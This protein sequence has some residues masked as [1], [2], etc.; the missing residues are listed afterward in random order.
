MKK[1]SYVLT[2]LCFVYAFIGFRAEA[3]APSIEWER[4]IGGSGSDYDDFIQQTKDGS[5][6]FAGVTN[7]NNS[8]VSGNQANYDALIAKLNAS[9]DI[10][11]QKHL[12]GSGFDRAYSI[13]QT[14][15]GGY[16]FA[17]VT[18]SND[19]DVSGNHGN[20]DAW[21]VKLNASGGIEWQKCLGGSNYDV[22]YSIRQTGDGGYIIAGSTSSDDGDVSGYHSNGDAW[23]VKL[24]SAG[25][26]EWQKCIGGSDMES[27]Y[28][29]QQTSDGGYIVAGG[30]RPHNIESF[31]ELHNA[32]IA[33]L[34]AA[35]GIVWRMDLGSSPNHAKSIRQTSDGGY[36]VVGH[37]GFTVD[38]TGGSPWIVKL[39]K[40]GEIAWQKNV[41]GDAKSIQITSNG[42]YII[43]GA[44]YEY[45][46]STFWTAKLNA[47][48][49]VVWQKHLK[50]PLGA[51]A[52][53]IQQTIDGGYIAAGEIEYS[54]RPNG[55]W[56]V[57]F[58]SDNNN[59][60]ITNGSGGGCNIAIGLLIVILM[61]PL[62]LRRKD[63]W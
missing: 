21:I 15:D 16:I 26:I 46:Y 27:A 50:G 18:N 43:A 53:T 11:W 23:I 38:N 55:T 31:N 39:N 57:K 35:G 28:Q 45:S 58:T 25:A 42:D 7:S 52:Y 20:S 13:Q 19:G 59:G 36:I 63:M 8:G 61:L 33:K 47:S 54:D 12:G 30:T 34:D 41:E 56:I 10:E 22:A 62:F 1:V 40:S 32:W 6:I 3:A 48:G 2:L 60:N 4:H 5:Y 37:P 17:G 44:G 24:N 9:G 29:I 49:E 51:K 14:R